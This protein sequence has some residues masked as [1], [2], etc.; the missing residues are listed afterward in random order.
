[1]NKTLLI[2]GASGDIGQA[3]AR[4]LATQYQTIYLHYNKNRQSVEEMKKELN[5]KGIN[6]FLVQ[7]NFSK[8]EGVSTALKQIHDPIDTIIHN[9]GS[10]QFGL[11]TD[12]ENEEVETF[13]QL[14]VTSPFLLSKALLPNMI[15]EK[16]GK[17]VVVS[18]IWGLT[19]AACEVLYSMVKGSQNAFVK[20][21]A[22]EVARSG[23]S[24]NAVAPGA[25]ETK[26]MSG[27]S[28]VEK[29]DLADEIPQGRLGTPSEVANVVAFLTSEKSTYING[30]IISINGAWHC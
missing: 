27:F 10:S 12:L 2:T 15:R 5:L 29:D 30:Q 28:E 1:M 13:V 7:A 20:G 6:V 3:I 19:G 16:Q 24:V 17:I 8:R 18:S 11:V 26:M 9:S 25:I 4:E 21:L 14:H 23:V 22:K